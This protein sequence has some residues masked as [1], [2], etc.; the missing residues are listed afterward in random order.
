MANENADHLARLFF[1]PTEDGS[2]GAY[3]PDGFDLRLR[4]EESTVDRLVHHHEFQHVLLT[5]TT[6]WGAALI[7]AAAVP[8]WGP[9]FDG[10][11]HH[12]RTTHESYATYLSLS[13]LAATHGPA[14]A[15]LSAY[16]EYEPLADRL[17]AH[18]AHV[19]GPHR[20]SLAATA[21]ARA[22]MQTP[23]LQAMV[24][25]WPQPITPAALRARDRPDDRLRRLLSEPLAADL[26][27]AADAAV[28]AQGGSD[29]L[30]ADAAIDAALDDAFDAAW[31]VWEDALFDGLARRLAAAGATVVA[32]NAHLPVAAELVARAG[33]SVPR[34]AVSVDPRPDR[35]DNRFVALALAHS[36]LW[37]STSRRPARLITV[38]V[39]VEPAEVV[40]VGEATTRLEGRP[41]LVFT[42]RLPRR[43]LNGYELP[44]DE[45]DAL[46]ALD[47]PVVVARTIADDGTGTETDAV[48]LA[49]LPEP[50]DASRVADAWAHVGD[51]SCCVAT[52]CLADAG[53]GRRWAPVLARLAPIVRL[54]DVDVRWLA[55][56]FRP[57]RTVHGLYLQLGP[58]ATG[59][60]RAVVFR[61]EGTTDVWLAV[62]DDVGIELITGQ[63]AD[64]GVDLRM[65]DNDWSAVLP[66]LR[67][68]LIDLLRTESYVDLR[69]L[70]RHER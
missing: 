30:D 69:A 17:D 6:A 29:A 23:V 12:C 33:A 49:R 53:W 70:S 58:S 13:V 56:D 19:P 14:R 28:L 5:S 68:V 18:L 22:C 21:L 7:V 50:A 52:S 3:R 9:L 47:G 54:I 46:A 38:G 59:A 43:L 37:L 8:E 45:R 4:G 10:L 57:G 25:A 42:V 44:D 24:D 32:S 1:A 35:P 65:T 39:D 61:A 62:G 11:L 64:L 15:A 41:N 26:V 66:T 48:W 34:W 60:R 63:V 2:R 16:P 40:R 67:L 51:L 20:R 31:A 36:R 27:R 55:G